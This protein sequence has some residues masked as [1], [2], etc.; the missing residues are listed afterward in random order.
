MALSV[1]VFIKRVNSKEHMST[2]I[3]LEQGSVWDGRRLALGS[4]YG[5]IM[6]WFFLLSDAFTFSAFLTA[7]GFFRF[8][9]TTWPSPEIVFQS[10]PLT[11][12]EHGAPLFLWE[13]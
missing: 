10:I 13:S 7:Y 2:E 1:F 3:T 5:K 9:S 8:S 12:V 11:G 6:M 4:T